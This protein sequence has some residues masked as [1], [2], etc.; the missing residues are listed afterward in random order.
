M[1]MEKISTKPEELEKILRNSLAGR[2]GKKERWRRKF[3]DRAALQ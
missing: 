3:K 2:I 1:A